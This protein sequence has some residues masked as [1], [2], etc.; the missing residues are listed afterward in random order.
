VR[1][2]G[3]HPIEGLACPS[4]SLCVATD[5]VGRALSSVDPA[6]GARAWTSTARIVPGALGRVSCPS[7]SLCAATAEGKVVTTTDPMGG[8]GSWSATALETGPPNGPSDVSCA[9]SDLCVAV[10]R[11]G[12]AFASSD[13]AAGTWSSLGIVDAFAASGVAFPA[14]IDSV[15]CP[16]SSFCAASDEASGVVATTDPIGGARPWPRSLHADSGSSFAR[17]SC[18]SPAF[19]A[20]AASNGHVYASTDPGA[21]AP[22]WSDAE[23]DPGGS[24]GAIDCPSPSLCVA[25]DL[26]SGD[27]FASTD[28]TGGP[29]AWSREEIDPLGRLTTIA[30]PS[31]SMCVAGDD[32][33]D[34]VVGTAP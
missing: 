8:S 18:P 12:A 7:P 2:E 33:G 22:H 25:T 30:C 23:V 20:V 9:G 11:S 34:V 3:R 24:L 16:T 28:P 13:P 15:S 6:G 4:P 5:E 27:A 1:I 31:E 19:C 21:A 14:A 10:D 29:G 17:I 32:S 26:F